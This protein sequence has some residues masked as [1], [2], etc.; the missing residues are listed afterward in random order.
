MNSVQLHNNELIEEFVFQLRKSENTKSNYKRDLQVF[1]R[2]LSN[3]D[4]SLDK[5][6]QPTVQ[7]FI[8]GLEAG[9]VVGATGKVLGSTTINR[10]FASIRSYCDYTNQHEAIQD[11][12]INKTQS[13]SQ[14]DSKAVA[15]KDIDSI[16][17]R[18][19]NSRKPSTQRDLAMFD[20]L[21]STGIRVS[22]LVMLKLDDIEYNK[23]SKVY[24]ISIRT[25]KGKVSRTVP[26]PK[27]NFQYIQ[28]Y[29]DTRT[30]DC[31]SLFVSQRLKQLTTRSIQLLLKEYD[32]TPHMLRHSFCTALARSGT[33]LTTVAALAGH[34]SL[35][36]TRRY[37][38]PTAEEKAAAVA[39]ALSYNL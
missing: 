14:Q 13:I 16:R 1:G 27:A 3:S 10:I 5:L 38:N 18:I 20:M 30:D 31:D 25:S 33:D 11:I 2:Y 29:M 6:T 28:R 39:K 17:L 32:I 8:Q 36:T 15:T 23:K 9:T 35:E 7:M 4:L 37:T 21:R 26:I 22:E 34:N 24:Y 19:A 12:V